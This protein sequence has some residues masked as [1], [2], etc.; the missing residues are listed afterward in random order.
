[1]RDDPNPQVVGTDELPAPI[2]PDD[3]LRV[4]DVD[5]APPVPALADSPMRAILDSCEELLL[6]SRSIRA[7]RPVPA[8]WQRAAAHRAGTVDGR[9]QPDDDDAESDPFFD[10]LTK[11]M[12][13]PISEE[14][15]ASAVVPIVARV[16][17]E[18][19]KEGKAAQLIQFDRPF[20][21]EAMELREELIG[22]IATGLDLPKEVVTG[23]VDLNHWTAW[24]V[25]DN[26]FRHH[27][28]PDVITQVDDLT[29]AYSPADAP[30]RPQHLG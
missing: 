9:C 1:M 16:P 21:A 5:A 3:V 4:P 20:D 27:I 12:L 22:R 19:L 7:H 10:E 29:V 26:T 11:A 6:L 8:R 2:D 13:T 25:D 28:E 15:D 17:G 23:V 18:M 24:Q 14:G 30:R